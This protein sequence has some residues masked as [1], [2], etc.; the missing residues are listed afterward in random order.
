MYGCMSKCFPFCPPNGFACAHIFV[1]EVGCGYGHGWGVMGLGGLC[2]YV[3]RLSIFNVLK[4]W[5]L[6]A[7]PSELMYISHRWWGHVWCPFLATPLQQNHTLTPPQQEQNHTLTYFA[8]RVPRGCW[9]CWWV[10]I[11]VRPFAHL[12]PLRSALFH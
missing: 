6:S 12:A 7:S 5:A 8:V 11:L 3:C 4:G 10:G 1:Y 9:L 2:A